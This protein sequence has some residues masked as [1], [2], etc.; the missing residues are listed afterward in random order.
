MSSSD[1]KIIILSVVSKLLNVTCM[2][3]KWII[4]TADSTSKLNI[5]EKFVSK[6]IWT[7]VKS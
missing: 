6:C 7:I 5:L 1:K 3:E 4:A 2:T